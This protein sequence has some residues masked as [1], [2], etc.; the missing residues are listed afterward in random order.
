M[1]GITDAPP[2]SDLQTN[3]RRANKAATSTAQ[4]LE[5]NFAE[6]GNFY[7]APPAGAGQKKTEKNEEK[8]KKTK[9]S[10]KKT[11]KSRKKQKT[12]KNKKTEKNRKKQKKTEKTEK[13]GIKN[14]I[15]TK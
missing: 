14:K 7:T 8:R 9:K 13:N 11:K 1:W 12:K 6:G 5:T 2:T 3:N 15:N 4:N 10:R